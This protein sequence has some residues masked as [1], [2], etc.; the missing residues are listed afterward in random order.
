MANDVFVNGREIA[1]KSGSG[2]TTAAFP[3][4][5]FTPPENP[6]TP[7]GVPVPYPITS[8]DRDTNEG[9]R[10]VSVS[11]KEAMQKNASEF[12]RCVG[13]EA[14]SAAKKGLLSSVNKG[15]MYFKAWS[16]NVKL[17]GENA[18]RHLDITT[19]NHASENANAA[20][21]WPFI[22]SDAISDDHPCR[23]DFEAERNACSKLEVWHTKGRYKGS[24]NKTQTQEN[25][26][27]DNNDASECRDAR[28][29]RLAPFKDGCCEGRGSSTY[30]ES[31]HLVED[32]WI[33]N[34]PAFPSY[35]TFRDAD[36]DATSLRAFLADNP[37]HKS[38]EDAPCVCAAGDKWRAEHG[39]FHVIQGNY[40][41]SFMAGGARAGKPWDY[42]AAKNG[43]LMAHEMV[44]GDVCNRDC[45]EAQLDAF[46]GEDLDRPL[47]PPHRVPPNEEPARGWTEQEGRPFINPGRLSNKNSDQVA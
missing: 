45:L 21:P 44:Y 23:N 31:H 10:S 14:G 3:D 37:S 36:V 26:C 16:M 9:T 43:G 30:S 27:A 24:L 29:C 38:D 19:S 12:K 8:I 25:I 11:G 22:N 15:R 5:C 33:K 34:N 42:A 18:C 7:P 32:H 39:E 46:Y 6:A 28:K 41:Q 17:E 1:C 40:E 20:V 4:V 2:K 35:H 47:N 13:D